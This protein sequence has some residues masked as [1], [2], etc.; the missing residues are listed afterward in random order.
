MAPKFR[1]ACGLP[2]ARIIRAYQDTWRASSAIEGASR[3]TH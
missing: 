3:R 1:E 2:E